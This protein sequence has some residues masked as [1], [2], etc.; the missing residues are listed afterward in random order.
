MLATVALTGGTG[1]NLTAGH[2]IV[3]VRYIYPGRAHETENPPASRY[4]L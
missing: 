2:V 3:I 1:A 4:G